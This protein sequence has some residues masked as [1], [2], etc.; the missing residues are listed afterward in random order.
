MTPEEIEGNKIIAEFVGGKEVD[1]FC[2]RVIIIPFSDDLTLNNYIT[3]AKAYMLD[4]EIKFHDSWDWTMPVVNKINDMGKAFSLAI[5]KNYIS[6]TV[7]KGGKFYKDFH[8]SHAEYIT[9]EQTAKQA[10]F[11]L[12]VKFIKWYNEQAVVLIC[13]NCKDYHMAPKTKC[14]CGSTTLTETHKSNIAFVKQK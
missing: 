9:N 13:N 7:E 4:Y 2:E 12:L 14:E 10:I 6:L 3:K 8:F 11:K 5:F 1:W